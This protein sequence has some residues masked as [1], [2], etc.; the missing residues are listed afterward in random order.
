MICLVLVVYFSNCNINTNFRLTGKELF[1]GTDYSE[2]LKLNKKCAI[3]F[4]ILALYRVPKEAI[5]LII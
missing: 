1:P 3:N 2:I 5:D 4:E